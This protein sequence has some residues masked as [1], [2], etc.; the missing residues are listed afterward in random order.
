MTILLKTKNCPMK[1]NQKHTKLTTTKIS[2]GN[3]FR[4]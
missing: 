2:H 1:N 4:D 3:N